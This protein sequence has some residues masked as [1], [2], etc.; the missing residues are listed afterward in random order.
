MLSHEGAC[1][2]AS[3][4]FAGRYLK[5]IRSLCEGIGRKGLLSQKYPG[6]PAFVP[7]WLFIGPVNFFPVSIKFYY[8]YYEYDNKFTRLRKVYIS[9]ASNCYVVAMGRPANEH[10]I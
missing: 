10:E 6:S 3:I 5:L 8:I 1:M 9:I 2:T 7:Y 4:S